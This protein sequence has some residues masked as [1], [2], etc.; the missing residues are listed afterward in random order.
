LVGDS[1]SA[2]SQVN[3]GS[4]LVGWVSAHQGVTNALMAPNPSFGLAR[5][6][7]AAYALVRGDVISSSCHLQETTL[8][9][10]TD[11]FETN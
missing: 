5:F 11:G 8:E 7:K 9:G 6:G 3:D 2:E 1:T 4:Q 10:G